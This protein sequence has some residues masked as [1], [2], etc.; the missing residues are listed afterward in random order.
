[1]PS[2]PVTA[3][4][5]PARTRSQEAR[6]KRIVDAALTLL[7]EREYDRI[8]VRD[9]ADA[10]SVALGT[11]YR[12]FPS[13]EHLFGEALVQWAGTLQ[14]SIT[15]RPLPGTDPAARLEDALHRSVRAFEHRPQLAKLVSR[16]EVSDDPFSSDVLTRLDATTNA[17]YLD[18]LADLGPDE[19]L[20]V[21]RVVD[22]VLDSQ[23][24]SWT[25]GRVTIDQVYRALSDAVDLLLG[26]RTGHSRVAPHGAPT[27]R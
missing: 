16:L 20:R 14:G 25:S 13:K 3:A 4:G 11:L 2:A 10:A 26:D 9:V 5:P 12:Y 8:Q 6:R 22:A 27:G 15:R 23:L 7:E 19:A 21:V 24:R 1:M 18:I 17:V